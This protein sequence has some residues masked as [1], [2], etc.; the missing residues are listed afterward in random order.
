MKDI[1]TRK[2]TFYSDPSHGW[3]KVP[4]KI[5]KEIGIEKEISSYSYWK[6]GNAY[7][8]EDMDLTTFMAN[9][10]VKVLMVHKNTERASRIRKYESYNKEVA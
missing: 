3:L 10:S 5:L 6:K 2:F 1:K 4:G 8:E 9:Y 7:L